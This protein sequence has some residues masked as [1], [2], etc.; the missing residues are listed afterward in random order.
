MVSRM[1]WLAAI[2]FAI[3]ALVAYG[4]ASALL[5]SAPPMPAASDSSTQPVKTPKGLTIVDW[6]I[7]FGPKRQ[8]LTLDYI[9]S[10]YTPNATSIEIT[11]RMVVIH[12]TGSN[13]PQSAWATFK[14]ERLPIWRTEIRKGGHVNVS[15]HFLVGRDGTIW[16]LMNEKWMA[17]HVIGLN[18][19]AIGVENVGGPDA[20][21]TE[22]QLTSNEQL[23]RNL[24]AAFPTLEFLIGHHEYGRFR[25]SQLWLDVDPN[26]FTIKS[27]PGDAFM[28]KLRKRVEDLALASNPDTPKK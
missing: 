26:Y 18:H 28:L 23:V 13:T 22:A 12:W 5:T 10:R 3:A 20:P 21:L 19:A 1:V 14:P 24:V 16:R 8:A 9:R 7:P 4:L 27:D 17:R 2:T 15:A 6:P 11:P 25:G